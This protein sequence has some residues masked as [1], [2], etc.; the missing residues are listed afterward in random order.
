VQLH[1]AVA[2]VA[3]QRTA[4]AV[5]APSG[6]DLA[7]GEAVVT[8]LGVSQRLDRSDETGWH[9]VSYRVV[10][11]DGH[12]STGEYR[13]RVRPAGHGGLPVTTGIWIVLGGGTVGVLALLGRAR[14][15]AARAVAPL[16]PRAT[17]VP[18]QPN[19]A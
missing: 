6:R 14:R 18:C 19:R 5:V 1:F 9:L 4:V 7:T 10:S 11:S 15:R 3:D 13:F 8:G 16:E 17:P 2:A 12:V